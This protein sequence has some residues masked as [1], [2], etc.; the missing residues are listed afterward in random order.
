MYNIKNSSQIIEEYTQFTIESLQQIYKDIRLETNKTFYKAITKYYSAMSIMISNIQVVEINEDKKILLDNILLNF[1][2]LIHCVVLKDIKLI[3]FIYRNII[4]SVIRYITNDITTRDLD[5]LFKQLTTYSSNVSS[6][7]YL[8]Q[9][10]GGQLKH[11]YIKNCSYVHTDTSK[12]PSNLINLF[13]YQNNINDEKISHLMGDFNLLN[14][15][16]ITLFKVF[17]KELYLGLSSNCKDYVDEITPLASRIE[18]K[19][20]L[21]ESKSV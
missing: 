20:F 19:E 9:K 18:Y 15:A 5:Q 8:V 6:G 21:N 13:D 10:H 4:E 12:I 17:Y 7:T 11:V 16:I 3:N 14:V 1:C 2:S